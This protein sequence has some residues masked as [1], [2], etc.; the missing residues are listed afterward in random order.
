MIQVYVSV[1]LFNVQVTARL[2]STKAG[3]L[4]ATDHHICDR[5]LHTLCN[6]QCRF[7]TNSAL[8]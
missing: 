8:I 3:L 2:P 5:E 7:Y 4:V 6:S 1:Y